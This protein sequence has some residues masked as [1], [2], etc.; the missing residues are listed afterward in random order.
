MTTIR[1]KRTLFVL[2]LSFV[3]AACTGTPVAQTGPEERETSLGKVLTDANGMTLYTYD[4]D[5]KG[6]A[7]CTGLCAIIWPPADAVAS[8]APTT[9]SISVITKPD[10]SHQWARDSHPLYAYRL[11]RVPGDVKGQGVDGVWQVAR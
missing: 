8:V 3:V 4:K 5:P 9:G 10:G 1:L 7:T 11:D 6:K 2:G